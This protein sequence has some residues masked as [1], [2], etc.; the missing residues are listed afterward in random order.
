MGH[1]WHPTG[2]QMSPCHHRRGCTPCCNHAHKP[3]ALYAVP[4]YSHTIL[5]PY[6]HTPHPALPLADRTAALTCH[7]VLSSTWC[8]HICTD[9]FCHAI[10]IG[11]TINQIIQQSPFQIP[12]LSLSPIPISA[13]VAFCGRCLCGA[14][15]NWHSAGRPRACGAP[16]LHGLQ[17]AGAHC[18]GCCW[19]T[20]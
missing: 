3:R 20:H 10:N 12:M 19:G 13:V 5:P 7:V 18:T 6:S 9:K 14:G 2:T 8:Q 11:Q 15:V 17:R 1:R 16:S 4:P